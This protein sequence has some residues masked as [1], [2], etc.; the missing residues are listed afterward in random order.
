MKQKIRVEYSE[1]FLHR[2]KYFHVEIFDLTK[3]NLSPEITLMLP[4]NLCI[5]SST[6]VYNSQ[7]DS[8]SMFVLSQAGGKLYLITNLRDLCGH[9]T[10][11][12]TLTIH[13]KKDVEGL[14][15]YY[16]CLTNRLIV[17]TTRKYPTIVQIDITL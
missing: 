16:S 8:V 6:F 3:T 1:R 7:A 2:K 4:S 17:S 5:A 15:V 13:N 14:C 10:L 11:D 12:K 9:V